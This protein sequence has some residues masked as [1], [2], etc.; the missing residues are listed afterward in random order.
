M[1]WPACDRYELDS[2]EYWKCICIEM[3]LTIY[4]PV[5]TCKMGPNPKTSVVSSRLKVHGVENLRVID[6]SIMPTQTSGNTNGPTGM[7]A[8]RGAE[9]VLEYYNK[10]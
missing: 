1:E 8:E 4:H 6:A 10:L 7:V 9:F 5:G 3:V 2:T